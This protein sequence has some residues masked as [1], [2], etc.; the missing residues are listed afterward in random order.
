MGRTGASAARQRHF[1]L[2]VAYDGAEFHGW[3]R[4]EEG[5]TVQAAIEETLERVLRQPIVVRG[6]GRTDAGVHALGQLVAFDAVTRLDAAAVRRA[7]NGLMSGAVRIVAASEHDTPIDP[8]RQAWRKTYLYQFHVGDLMPPDRRRHFVLA[9]PTLDLAAMRR[10]AAHFV[11]V[12]DFTSFARAEAT[13]RGAVRQ[14]FAVRVWRIPSGVRL[15]F[16]GS[17][18]LYNM[19]RTLAAALLE[20]GRGRCE[21]DAIAAMIAARDRL[22]VPATLPA[23]GLLLWRVDLRFRREESPDEAPAAQCVAAG[24]EATAVPERTPASAGLRVR[25]EKGN[26][27][28]ISITIRHGDAS[29]E[30]T[31]FAEEKC[32][33]LEKFLRDSPRIEFVLV[34]DHTT[35]S[36]EAI[37]HGSRHHERLVAKDSHSDPHHC[38]ELLVE[39]LVRQLEKGKERRKDHRGPS[40]GDAPATKEPAPADLPSYEEIVRRKLDGRE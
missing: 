15:F 3:Q 27:V 17:G 11:G 23:R 22:R 9:G 12:H 7:L 30:L 38:V 1:L 20:V 8:R 37:L 2:T 4:Q 16:S 39:K 10:A 6:S 13:R 34:K 35:W 31:A 26:H 21:P 28:A 18:F 36:G 14:I 5:A 25:A 40:L 33:R 32:A 19:V 24:I 29:P